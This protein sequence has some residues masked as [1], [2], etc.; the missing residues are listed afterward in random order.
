MNGFTL[1][2]SLHLVSS[3]TSNVK[4]GTTT[5]NLTVSFN[6][7]DF[8][9]SNYSLAFTKDEVSN[10]YTD[11]FGMTISSSLLSGASID[12]D[13][14]VPFAGNKLNSPDNPVTGEMVV[15]GSANTKVK[16][17]ANDNTTYSIDVDTNGDDIYDT[18]ITNSNDG[19]LLFP[20]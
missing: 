8:T 6:G 1:N 13:T 19:T 16:A 12:V 4:S 9:I 17:T 3:T 14:T 11:N 5:G 15:T 7:A 2:G 18:Q 10:D 20:W